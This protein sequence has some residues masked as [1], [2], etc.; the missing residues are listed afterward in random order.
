MPQAWYMMLFFVGD[1]DVTA[2]A[3][4]CQNV[5]RLGILLGS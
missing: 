3:I 1:K 2:V 5:R 4:L